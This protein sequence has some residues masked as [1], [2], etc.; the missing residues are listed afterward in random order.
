MIELSYLI[1]TINAADSLSPDEYLELEN[2]IDKDLWES[3]D[4]VDRVIIELCDSNYKK[5]EIIEYEN[6]PDIFSEKVIPIL[7]G[8]EALEKSLTFLESQDIANQDEI[9]RIRDF[10]IIGKKKFQY[11][12]KYQ[13]QPISNFFHYK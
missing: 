10:I 13:Q 9:E 7:E 2:I 8:I 4:I 1:S 11:S 6:Q 5:N 3:S 12:K